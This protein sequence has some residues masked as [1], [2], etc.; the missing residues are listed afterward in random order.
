MDLLRFLL[1]LPFIVVR[2]CYKTVRLLLHFSG[3]L[4]RPL[5]GNWQAPAWLVT[6]KKY[7]SLAFNTTESWITNHVKSVYAIIILSFACAAGLFYGYHWYLNQPKP[8][9]AV[10]IAKIETDAV[11][12]APEPI[13]YQNPSPS[14]N[15]LFVQ[16]YHSVAPLEQIG[17]PVESGIELTPSISGVW[18][19]ADESTLEFRPEKAFPMGKTYQLTLSEQRLF[20]PHVTLNNKKHTFTTESF[21]YD[22]GSREFY[23]DPQNPSHKSVLFNILFNAPVDVKS[24]EKQISLYLPKGENKAPDAVHYSVTYNQEKTEA[25]IR[26]ESLSLPDTSRQIVLTIKSGVT[27]SVASNTTTEPSSNT[28]AIPGLYSLN[29]TNIHATLADVESSNSKKVLLVESSDGVKDKELIPS[30]DAWLLPQHDIRYLDARKDKG[31][32]YPWSVSAID[33]QV[34]SSATKV[35]LTIGDAE[36][37]YSTLH[38]FTFDAPS[39]RYMLVRIKPD[40][41]SSGGYKMSGE[42]YSVV[43]VPDYPPILRFMS[44]GSLLSM[45]G[46]KTL[47]IAA[48]NVPGMKL[49]IKRVIPDQLQHLVSFNNQSYGYANFGQLSDEYFTEYFEHTRALPQNNPGEIVYQ[50]MDLSDYLRQESLPKR[51]IFLV[52]LSVWSP[53]DTNAHYHYVANN[54]QEKRLIVLTDLGILAKRSL[55]GEQDV[56]IQSIYDGQPVAGASVS[57]IGKNGLALLTKQTDSGGHVSFP[58]LDDYRHEKMPTMYLVEKEGDISFLP[59]HRNYDRY[60]NLSRFDTGGDENPIDPRALNSYLF[61]DRGVYRPGDAFHIGLIT[62]TADWSTS[63]E[64]IPLLAEIRDPRGTLMKT[65]PITLDQYG[66]NELSYTTSESSPTGEWL[67]NLFTISKQ[68]ERAALLGF[69]KVSVKEFE[70]DRMK[71]ELQL[72]AR[73]KQG[74]LK[75]QDLTAQINVQNLFGTAAQDRRV[76]PTMSLYPVYPRFD[77]Y[78]DY[79]F[80]E[81]TENYQG[82]KVQLE[83]QQ[84]DENG[85]ATIPLDLNAY[86]PA[87]YQLQLLSEAFEAGGGRSVAA[88]TSALISPYD[89]LIGYK[90]DGSLNYI[91]RNAERTLE[92]IAVNPTLDKIAISDLTVT[93]LEQKYLS[94]LTKQRSG[95]YKYQSKLKELLI[96]EQP[97]S[98][99][100]SGTNYPL[101]TQTPGNYILEIKDSQGNRLNRISYSIAGNANITRSLDRNAELSIKLNKSSYRPGEEIEVA[102]NA[103]YT[104]TGLITIERDKVYSWQWFKTDTTSSVQKITVPKGMEGNGYIN[105][106]FVRDIH[107]DEIFMSPLSYSV[108][109]FTISRAARIASIKLDAPEVIKPGETL[110]I[111]AKTEGKQRIA[112]FA[113]DEGILQVAQYKLNDPLNYFLRKRLLS[114]ESAQILDLILPEFSKQ[115]YL[116]SAPGGDAQA[117]AQAD[118]VNM[119][120]NPFKRERD[121]PVVYWSG[122]VDIDGE[123]A[124]DYTIPDYF[125]GKIRLMAISVSPE[126]IGHTQG[127]VIVK[128][129]FVLTPN[130]PA[131]VAPGDE[132]EVTLGVTNN[133]DDTGSQPADIGISLDVPPQ[134]SLI[135]EITEQISLAAK[136]EG[137]LRYRFKAREELGNATLTFSAN[138]QDKSARRKASISVRP[139][140]P[141]RT[142]TIMGRMAGNKEK[143]ANLRSMY[144]AY[145]KRDAQ[146]S[147][148]PFVLTSGLANYLENYP[149][150]CSEQ[151]TSQAVP[152]LIQNNHPELQSQL[153]REAQEQQLSKIMNTLLSRQNSAGGIGMWR[154]SLQPDP[155]LTPYIVQFLLEA[156]ESHYPIPIEMLNKANRYLDKLASDHSMLSL[157]ELRL[158]AYATYLLTRQQQVTTNYL[159]SIQSA[160]QNNHAK[161]W[162]DDLSAVY[163]AAAYKLLKMDKQADELLQSP[164]KSLSRAYNQAWWTNNY[165]DPLVQNATLLYLITRHFPEKVPSIPAQALENMVLILKEERYTTHSAAMSILALE[166]YSTLITTQAGNETTLT[167]NQLNDASSQLISTMN[168]MI[169]QASFNADTQQLLINNSQSIPAWYSVTQA[170]FDNTPPQKS[171]KQGLE[172]VREYRNDDGKPVNEIMLGDTLYVHLKIRS[173]SD[174][175]LTN[176]AIVDLL[177]GGFEVVQQTAPQDESDWSNTNDEGWR[178]P[179]TVYGSSWYPDYSDIREDRVIIYG[180]ATKNVREFIYAIKATNVGVYTVPPAFG[181]A[182][183]NR[184]I[185]A[186]SLGGT[187]IRVLP[188]NL[189]QTK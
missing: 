57:V 58:S 16:F 92:F 40:L 155:F 8:I 151:L 67:I 131:M 161:T 84:T 186:L 43:Q 62:R 23:Q 133:L 24:F 47:T 89:Y 22:F 25:W 125:N 121:K 126:R 150:Y 12:Y 100:S 162:Q 157:Y 70:P 115:M 83:D 45:S 110:T 164:W 75:P 53:D 86:A 97:L 33:D 19:W 173:N 32:Y 103:P 81:N 149:Y 13:D 95:I 6:V 74:W 106:Q 98:I 4:L 114:V 21:R 73:S 3:Q 183:Y 181:E 175:Y 124:F 148:S 187:S 122:I 135:G 165:Y 65:V 50:G 9:S 166:S 145:A 29:I 169:A 188:V 180:S 68:N 55:H 120:L 36:Q 49:S 128:D 85:L 76:A 2:F 130:I 82:F 63:L 78:S 61:S 42:H 52:T 39:L 143:I 20:E 108:I 171:I 141:F 109:P 176:L 184:D 185:Q 118:A 77:R 87:T 27:A 60:L 88:T 168:G 174:D 34:L 142:Q 7:L 79:L 172:I 51:G 129:D 154:S 54:A 26:S 136:R 80:Y 132:F 156:Q 69:T 116:T 44:Q 37:T 127:H 113:V 167:I 170:G 152:L 10:A 71:V 48:R 91:N 38:N 90:S 138:Y 123:K 28:V 17:K 112:V 146:V 35:P 159:A 64:G 104:G 15:S 153:S 189:S 72:S 140:A 178:S 179:L 11:I 107:S 117:E 147:Y 137:M 182:M 46:E 111:Q 139:A 59:I 30:I 41:N 134:L 93:L 101:D 94:V 177:P 66:F 163:L 31:Y 119:H 1:Q 96:S 56:F 105:V 158:R 160:L 99:S 102:I 14:P 18:T 5:L 144:D